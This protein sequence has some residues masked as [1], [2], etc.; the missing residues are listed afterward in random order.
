MLSGRQTRLIIK[1][2]DAKRMPSL[3]PGLEDEYHDQRTQFTL[4]NANRCLIKV[5]IEKILLER[6]SLDS[7]DSRLWNF[8]IENDFPPI[9]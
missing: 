9:G 2:A 6:F 5:F 3:W 1:H 4:I 8:R 7:L